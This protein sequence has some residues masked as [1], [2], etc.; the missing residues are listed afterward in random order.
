MRVQ[1]HSVALVHKTLQWIMYAERKLTV[2]ELVEI[3]S[4]EDDDDTLDFEAYPDPE[5][6][7]R[8]CGSLIR[9]AHGCL[10]LAHF[11][12]QEFLEAIQPGDERLSMFQI[13][14]VDRIILAKACVSYLC[15]RTFDQPPLVLFE[16]DD[17]EYPFYR[18][19]SRYF[20]D[21]TASY[22]DDLDFF[23][24]IQEL[25]DPKK[26]YNFT[27]LILE[28]LDSYASS[29]SDYWKDS[30]CSQTFGPLHAAAMLHMHKIC[31]W[32]IDQNCEVNK[33][34]NFGMPLEC[35]IYGARNAFDLKSPT[36]HSMRHLRER[37]AQVTI[38][39]LLHA[40]SACDRGT[41]HGHSLISAVANG[42]WD[43]SILLAMMLEHGMPLE[44]DVVPI[45]S[46]Y[47]DGEKQSFF[48]VIDELKDKIIISPEVKIRL[49]DFAHTNSLKTAVAIPFGESMTDETF[50]EALRHAVRFNQISAF[51]KLVVDSK[52]SVELAWAGEDGTYL[53]FA[54]R[55][56]S[57]QILHMLLDLGCD[58]T[59]PGKRGR[60]VLH[61]VIRLGMVNKRLLSRL[62]SSEAA[63]V[64]DRQGRSVW[65]EAASIGNLQA[66]Q[67]LFEI[68]GSHTALLHQPCKNGYTPIIEAIL[69]QHT[70]CA[71]VLLLETY[72]DNTIVADE[73]TLHYAV[74]MGLASL[75]TRLR[76]CGA[77][78]CA[79][80]SKKQTVL[81]SLTSFTKSDTMDLLL[82]CGLDRYHLDASGRSPLVAFL[83][84]DE[85]Q[86]HLRLSLIK[87]AE[88][89]VLE[90]SVFEALAD[91]YAVAT[92]DIDGHTAWF[93]FCT[94][95]VPFIVSS[96]ATTFGK[97]YSQEVYLRQLLSV[98]VD[99]EAWKVYEDVTGTSGVVLLVKTCLDSAPKCDTTWELM[100]ASQKK[101]AAI[102]AVLIDIL[103]KI[104]TA[105][106]PMDIANDAQIIRLLAW[107][108][109]ASQGLLI[110]RLLELGVD[111]HSVSEYHQGKTPIDESIVLDLVPDILDLLLE[112]ADNSRLLTV[113]ETGSFRHFCLCFPNPVWSKYR[114]RKL[115]ALLEAGVDP[116]AR[117]PNSRTLAHDAAEA[118][119]LT[120]L[121]L[122]VRFKADLSLVDMYGWTVIQYALE[123]GDMNL[124]RFVREHLSED[125]YWTAT[126]PCRGPVGQ[127]HNTA[128]GPLPVEAYFG[129]S[130][131]HLGSVCSKSTDILNFLKETGCF[132][133][134]DVK[135]HEGVTPLHFAACMRSPATVRWLIS[136]G[137]NVHID[138]GAKRRTALHY[139]LQ[140]GYLES[141][142]V[143]IEAGAT[144]ASDSDGFTPEMR[145]H[146]Q[147]HGRLMAALPHCGV[148]VPPSVLENLRS[149]HGLRP[150]GGLHRAISEG[151]YEACLSVAQSGKR[152]TKSMLECG[153]C[154]PLLIALASGR[155][156]I[157]KV[158]LLHGATTDGLP[159]AEVRRMGQL[160]DSALNIAISQPIFNPILEKL[161]ELT[162]RYESHWSQ[163]SEI[164]QPLHLAAA[165]NAKSI[166]TLLSHVKKNTNLI[167]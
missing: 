17:N 19:A 106:T 10:E 107:S 44:P 96:I 83:A 138:V 139:A 26:S 162:L 53:H 30:V 113:D 114:I 146:P 68:H 136:N 66:L 74:A 164:W 152:L 111:V 76:D 89:H 159:C 59:V 157:A 40:G 158:F 75:L 140:L 109:A 23:E 69:G 81:Y 126:F 161:L 1:E 100:D 116:D 71:E 104:Y 27:F 131:L 29:L 121:Q 93:Y 32:L 94:R 137:A 79:V 62:I 120:V 148:S 97:T 118:G 77:E 65:H 5:D 112:R 70:E 156:D 124:L 49:L 167:T 2:E 91:T 73:R 21:Y 143:L 110:K 7:L 20:V 3:V 57:V 45:I 4:L 115:E 78:L 47:S 141:A 147:F 12:V 90:K 37:A 61:D 103:N 101:S 149:D 39:V 95:M 22:Q 129:C 56:H 135:S 88:K 31:Q 54:A 166:E 67:L 98:L 18:Y 33:V 165:F 52:S 6:L 60:S 163:G 134:M 43:P 55:N 24:Q 16:R 102:S 14:S 51:E 117:A 41:V 154:T 9:K 155:L 87:G 82:S 92:K 85:R 72:T 50:S 144:F 142:L 11:T 151:D 125:Q 8:S 80:S 34:S 122:L 128:S 86:D 36:R 150:V 132:N 35:A 42:P 105:G 108:V 63:K 99:Y 153:A 15:L 160:F 123:H 145:V 13:S 38:S 84:L 127:P 64:L 48:H 133:D 28:H 25:F 58:P 130:L 119:S 46:S